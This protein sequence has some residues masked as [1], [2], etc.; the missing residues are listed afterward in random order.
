MVFKK[1]PGGFAY[2]CAL[3]L[4]QLIL[5]SCSDES[6]HT[7][8]F[9]KLNPAAIGIDFQNTLF[10]TEDFNMY[11]F[12]NFYNGGGVAAGDLSGNG[13]P[14]LF[15]TGNMVSN[16]LYINHGDFVFEDVTE[17]A[18]LRSDDYWSTG[19]SFADVN[20]N[21]LLDIFVARSGPEGGKDRANRLYINNGDLTFTEQAEAWGVA[22]IGLSTHAVFFD[23]DGDGLPDLYL[24]SNSFH[25]M[26]SFAGITAAARDIPDPLGASKL[27]RNEGGYF[28]DV[29]QEAGLYSSAIGFGLSAVAADINRNG[30]PDLYVANDFFERDYLYLN[31]G[32]GTFTESL[33]ELLPSIS[34]SSMGTDIADLNNDGWPEMYVTDMRPVGQERLRSKMTIESR[35]EYLQNYERGF[36]YKYTR[37]TL[38]LNRGDGRFAE[39]GRMTGMEATEWS[40][41]ALMADFNLN[42]YQ[43]VFVANGIYNDLLDQDYIELVANPARIREM[44]QAG[45]EN[46]ILNLLGEMSSVPVRNML[47][48][49][50]GELHFEEVTRLWGL[51]HPAFSTGAAWADLNGDGALDLVVSNVN[52]PPMIYRNRIRELEPERTF[53]RVDLQGESPNTHALGAQLHVYAGDRY[54]YREHSLQRGFQSSVEPGLFVGTGETVQLDS[55]ILRWPDGRTSRKQNIAL[56]SRILLQESDSTTQPAPEPMRARNPGQ[57]VMAAQQ[58]KTWDNSPEASAA[59]TG[60]HEPFPYSDFGREQL[61]FKMRS[62]EGPATCAGQLDATGEPVFYIGGARNQA[63]RLFREGVAGQLMLLQPELFEAQRQAEDTDCV[64]FDATGN[65]ADDLYV[66]SG[67]ASF[68]ATSSGLRDRFYL[69]DG[70]GNFTL[71]DQMLPASGR[72]ESGSVVRSHDFTGNG[73]KDLFVGTRYRLF[74]YGMPAA[75]YLL[76]NEGD[77]RFRDVTADWLPE[78]REAGMVTAAV[79]ADLTGDGVNELAI[80]EEWGPVRVFQ[81]EGNR[82]SEITEMLGLDRYTG[83]WTSLIAADLTGD[84]QKSLIAGNHGLNSVFRA[85]AE[86][87]VRMVVTD[88]DGNGLLDHLIA[89]PDK[90][91]TYFPMVLR[92]DFMSA[93]PAYRSRY[94]THAEFAAA[95]LQDVLRDIPSQRQRVHEVSTLESLWFRKN[96]NGFEAVPL[97]FAAQLAPVYAIAAGDFTGNSRTELILGG[98]L[99]D[100]KPQ[101]GKYD[102]L[103]PTILFYEEDCDCLQSIPARQLGLDVPG[104]LRAA[105]LYPA[106]DSRDPARLLMVRRG[107]TPQIFRQVQPPADPS[108]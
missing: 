3:L 35:G 4:V 26:E 77:G 68:S 83:W 81:S 60:A 18:G 48:A 102:A 1:S 39:I 84:G 46:V 28:R 2:I 17:Q 13:L 7:A 34:F 38:Q 65:G 70:R 71:S 8:Q 72:F 51:D 67:G 76:E 75:S 106:N 91:G 10:P 19:V 100:V 23:Y 96:G 69:N 58:S 86:E 103:E 30:L 73:L 61:L 36:H 74:A 99:Y 53:L 90:Q 87:P 40:W 12:R 92:P 37:N 50:Q 14:D 11:I 80:A 33:E 101:T 88:L 82:F 64:F 16:R 29:T 105:V 57:A 54:W 5:S 63:G 104:E 15:F 94:P 42:G 66:V 21:G 20:G 22:D 45:E 25:N 95:S 47:F 24:I 78:L 49:N 108:P 43:D 31:N 89:M 52:G 56:P 107:D 9:E 41:A 79:W 93:A 85:T 6:P 55:L 62:T 59:F 32:D 27:Y 98:N 44:I 97:P